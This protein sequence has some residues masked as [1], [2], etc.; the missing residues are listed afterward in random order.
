MPVIINIV[1][2]FYTVFELL[3]SGIVRDR[4]GFKL[5]TLYIEQEM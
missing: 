2:W 3:L 1:G 4:I 5:I